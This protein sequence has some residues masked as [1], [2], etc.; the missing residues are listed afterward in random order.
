MRLTATDKAIGELNM[1]KADILRAKQIIHDGGNIDAMLSDID[2]C[3]AILETVKPQP[4]P[5]KPSAARRS[6]KGKK[7]EVA[8]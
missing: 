2:R 7:S 8:E 3:I 4:K 5:E 6:R 1:Q